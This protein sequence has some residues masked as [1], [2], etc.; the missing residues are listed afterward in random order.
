MKKI[1]VFI[2]GVQKG[3]TSSLH[4][5]MT[6]HPRIAAPT[7]K[8]LHFFDDELT[9]DWDDPDYRPIDA[10]FDSTAKMWIDSTPIYCFWPPAMER[11]ATYNPG[12]KIIVVF[13]DPIER[14]WSHWC[15]E[16]ARGL[17]R[18]GFSEAIRS[19]TSRIGMALSR[20]ARIYSYVGRGYYHGQAERILSLFPREQVLFLQAEDVWQDDD[21][22]MREIMDFLG[23]DAPPNGTAAHL[24]RRG[25]LEDYRAPSAEDFRFLRDRYLADVR[26]FSALTGIDVSRW[27]TVTGRRHQ[28]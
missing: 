1:D 3:G 14:A 16:H 20:E 2:C 9:V 7:R 8:E 26:E 28:A 10:F 27:P 6:D 11:I 12:A 22:R 17:E 23:L 18:Q 5:R 24:M 25:D 4:S 21:F 13:R 15:M 19:E